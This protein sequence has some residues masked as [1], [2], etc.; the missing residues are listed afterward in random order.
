MQQ[1][2]TV[3]HTEYIQWLTKMFE[4]VHVKNKI[5]EI[6]M[7]DLSFGDNTISKILS[8]ASIRLVHI[9]F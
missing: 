6:Y 8:D 7:L 1:I 9:K 4:R 5:R 2:I 3:K